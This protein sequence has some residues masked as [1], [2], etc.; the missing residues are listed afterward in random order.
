[1]LTI[2]TSLKQ[3]PALGLPIPPLAASPWIGGHQSPKPSLPG[4]MRLG[5]S[6][7]LRSTNV[8]ISG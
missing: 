6:V 1:M 3:S 7:A 4:Q 8:F 5:F 2:E